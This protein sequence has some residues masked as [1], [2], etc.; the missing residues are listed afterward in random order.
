MSDRTSSPPPEPARDE[1]S[2]GFPRFAKEFP[3]HPELDA[4]VAA[5]ANGDYRTV[6]EGAPKLA[7]STDDEAV[8]R[9]AEELAARIEPDPGAKILFGV[10]AA[11]LLFLTIW[12]VAHDGPPDGTA[13]PR[14][15]ATTSGK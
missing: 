3:R 9:A 1:S 12:W 15:P 2:W 8:K 4:L 10:T 11:L 5:F 13:A 7:K 14:P 6:R